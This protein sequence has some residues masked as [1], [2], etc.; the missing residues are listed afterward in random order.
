MRYILVVF[1]VWN[2]VVFAQDSIPPIKP[3]KPVKQKLQGGKIKDSVRIEDYKII[4]YKRDTVFLDTTLSLKKEY[5]YNYLRTDGFETMPFANIGKPV[6]NLGVD[7]NAVSMYP[8]I[9]AKALHA[10]YKELQDMRYYNVPTP[11]TELMFKTT[12]GKGQLLDALLTF[13]TSRQLNFAIGYK[14]F[15]SLGK[16]NYDQAE[17]GNFIVS[18][19][20]KTK[21]AKYQMMG[22]IASQDITFEENGG[23]S[24]KED[25]FELGDPEFKNRDRLDLMFQDASAVLSG[26]R[27][28]LDHQYELI[29]KTKDS[30]SIIATSIVLGH[31]FNYETKYAQFRQASENEYFGNSFLSETHDKA[32]LK[33]TYNQLNAVFDNSLLGTLEGYVGFY[34]YNYYFNSILITPS[35]RIGNQLKGSE[36]SLGATY[37]KKIG[38]FNLEGEAAYNLSGDLGGSLINAEAS[39][40]FKEKHNFKAAIHNESKMPNFNYLLH[41][42]NYENYNWDTT[43]TFKKQ[44][45][46]SL[47]FEYSSKVIGRLSLKY[48]NLGNYTYFASEATQDEIDAGQENAFIKPF[49]EGDAVGYMKLK[50]D[51]E[52]KKGY[53][54]LNNTLMYQN[55]SQTNNVLNVPQFVTRNTLYFSKTI[56]KGAMFLQTGVT[57]KYFT[58]YHMNAYNPALGEFYSQDKEKLGGYPMFDFFING[59]VKQTRIYLKAEH[60][61]SSFTGYNYYAAPNYP[62]RDFVIRFGLVWNFF[63]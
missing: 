24:N 29:G 17:S 47:L 10:N 20:Y 12:M 50:Y 6:N 49:Q 38:A 1:L 9:G 18:T 55:V 46:N 11:L 57:F 27:Y 59:K 58:A 23:L 52:F 45:V 37:K 7:F 41:Q 13:N 62:Y 26:K 31:Q 22:H 5:N 42:S 60:F 39:Y 63:S 43:D 16:Y 19:N 34:K 21:N 32:N 48:T 28:F 14:G 44:N 56:F 3:M 30:A 51:K 33:T 40:K 2:S 61:N 36:I 15:R 4:S 53:F 35:G 8:S 25:Q 54:A